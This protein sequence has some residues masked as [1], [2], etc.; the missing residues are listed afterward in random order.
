MQALQYARAASVARACAFKI[1]PLL[2]DD[3]LPF[4]GPASAKVIREIL[5]TGSCPELDAFR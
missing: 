5:L 2:Q 3:E 1:G 4:V